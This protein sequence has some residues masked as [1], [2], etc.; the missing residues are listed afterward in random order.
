MLLPQLMQPSDQVPDQGL[1]VGNRRGLG[2]V[3]SLFATEQRPVRITEM[4]QDIGVI[5]EA[6]WAMF[7]VKC[8]RAGE[9]RAREIQDAI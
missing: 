1:H 2:F 4:P 7:P 6:R 3:D 5:T 9:L 8:N